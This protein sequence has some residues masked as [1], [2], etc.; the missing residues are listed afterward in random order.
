VKGVYLITDTS[1]GKMYVGSAYGDTGIWS[2]WSCYITSGHGWNVGV[3]EV[4]KKHGL[5]Y[6]RKNFQ[7]SLLEIFTMK[8]DDQLIIDREQHWKNALLTR[9]FGYNKN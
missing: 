3:K 7:L 6:A 2:R 4:I 5:D 8:T 9:A 1:N